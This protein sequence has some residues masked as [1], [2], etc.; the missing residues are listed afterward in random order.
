V[1]NA[2]LY[3]PPDGKVEVSVVR[4][5]ERI[6]LQVDDTGPGIPPAERT[7]IFDRFYRILDNSSNGCGI[8]L[9][10]VQEIAK[11]HGGH[12]VVNESALGIGAQFCVAFKAAVGTPLE[13]AAALTSQRQSR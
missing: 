5:D 8:G 4:E 12:V 13:A 9:A 6:I 3:T 1:E 11:S 2:V 10:I 7:R